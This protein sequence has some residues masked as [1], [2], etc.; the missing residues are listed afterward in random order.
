[1]SITFTGLPGE[2][3]AVAL[4]MPLDG[5]VDEVVLAEEV[6]HP[7]TL[8]AMIIE[9]MITLTFIRFI[10][11]PRSS[12]TSAVR[13]CGDAYEWFSPLAAAPP[14]ES[15]HSCSLP[16]KNTSIGFYFSI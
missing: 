14:G 4:P 2:R 7:A 3:A 16:V 1:M 8:A 13:T 9:P 10:F 6:L 11:P 12:P 5:E 15:S